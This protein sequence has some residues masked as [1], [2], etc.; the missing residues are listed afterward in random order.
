MLHRW[1]TGILVFI[2]V[3]VLTILACSGTTTIPQSPAS[4]TPTNQQPTSPP[5][6]VTPASTT[7]T[8]QLPTSP[9]ATVTPPPPATGTPVIPSPTSASTEIPPVTGQ[10]NILDIAFF[11]DES[12]YWYFY[13][14]VRNDTSSTISDLQIEIKLLDNAGTA[15]Y[16]Y[17]TYTMLSYLTPGETSPF[18]DFTTEAFTNGATVQATVVGS[19]TTDTI[20]R[21]SLEV[22]G[23]SLWADDNNDVYLAGEVFNGNPEP[24]ELNAVTATLMDSSGKLVTAA[25]AYTSLRYIEPNSSSPFVMMFDAPIGQ[26]GTLTNYILYLDGII[27]NPTSTYDL[28]LSD[29]QYNYQDVNG[30]FHLAGSV[31]NNTSEPMII[32]LVA[33][34]YDGTGNCIDANYI[35]F[36]MPINS[37]ETL[38]YDFTLWGVMDNV[39]AAH[40]A[41]S[42][43]K[44]MVDWIYTYEASSP[45][46]VLTTED[47][48][49]T[50]EGGSGVFTGTAINNS[51]QDLS[52]V[53]V[54]ISLYNESSGELIATGSSFVPEAMPNNGT[55]SYEV[56]LYPP[57]DIDPA[58][59]NI[60]ITALG[61]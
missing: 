46:F 22:R 41:A 47:N 10:I 60:E 13:G 34:A 28:S 36:L 38:P 21:A 61:Q 15:I 3:L 20:D 1:Q 24:V 31:T 37:G 55:G 23:I 43:Y 57:V 44:V 54:I 4:T 48:G 9:P 12:D 7:P 18:S 33:G 50:F 17:T 51:G 11:K 32:Y 49:N 6:T 16:S 14:L 25:A 39:P 59:I 30:D 40:A 26:A 29:T 27:T 35:Y 52:S 58:D 56:T 45:A 2:L 19:S 5:A 53:I 8:N 42:N